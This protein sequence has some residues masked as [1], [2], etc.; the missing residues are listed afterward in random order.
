MQETNE[1]VQIS[2]APTSDWVMDVFI[3]LFNFFDLLFGWMF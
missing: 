2:G 3:F 1:L